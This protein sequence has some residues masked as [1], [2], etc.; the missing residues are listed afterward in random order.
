MRYI[1]RD[2]EGNVVGA[3]TGPQPFDTEEVPDDHPDYVAF[4][5]PK[6]DAE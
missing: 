3:F 1:K 5:A 6:D 4:I 2:A